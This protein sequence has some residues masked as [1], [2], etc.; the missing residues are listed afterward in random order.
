MEDPWHAIDHFELEGKVGEYLIL[1]VLAAHHSAVLEHEVVE[2]VRVVVEFD[3][4]PAHE[5]PPEMILDRPLK[6]QVGSHRIVKRHPV[7]VA[8][9][10]GLCLT[11]AVSNASI[12]TR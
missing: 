5:E 11:K 1:A 3:A 8:Q 7:P 6:L 10:V 12:I 4:Q 9:N 2:E